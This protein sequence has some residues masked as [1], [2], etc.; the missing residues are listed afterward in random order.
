L[1]LSVFLSCVETLDRGEELFGHEL[2]PKIAVLLE[3]VLV[4]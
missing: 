3:Q 2:I 1:C 4:Q